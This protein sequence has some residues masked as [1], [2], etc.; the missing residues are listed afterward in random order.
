MSGLGTPG[1]LEVPAGGQEVAGSPAGRGDRIGLALA[2]LV[3][4][5]AVETGVRCPVPVVTMVTVANPLPNSNF[6]VATSV[7]SG[8]R[9]WVV[10][11]CAP[12]TPS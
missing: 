8:A 7:P 5:H 6:A 1:H 10:K 4:V 12:G 3:N 11:P 9:S 2:R